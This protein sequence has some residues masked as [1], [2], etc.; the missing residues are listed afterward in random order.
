[1]SIENTVFTYP[2][3][4][5]ITYETPTTTIKI[6][7]TKIERLTVQNNGLLNL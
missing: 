3:L 5:C 7:S 6:C 2:K 4:R 1:M